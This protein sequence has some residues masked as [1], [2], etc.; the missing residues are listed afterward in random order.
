LDAETLRGKVDDGLLDV[1]QYFTDYGCFN[2]E[3]ISETKMIYPHMAT[4]EQWLKE[5]GWIAQ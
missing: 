3:D 4:F 5:S 2:G 1:M